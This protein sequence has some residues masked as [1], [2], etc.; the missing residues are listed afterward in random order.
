MKL[1]VADYYLQGK[2]VLK[3]RAIEIVKAGGKP[4]EV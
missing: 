3:N 1:I 4:E 2:Y